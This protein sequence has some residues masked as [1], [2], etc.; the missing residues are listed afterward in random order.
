MA[1]CGLTEHSGPVAADHTWIACASAATVQLP[2]VSL[3]YMPQ[4]VM[5][6]FQST[7]GGA[8]SGGATYFPSRNRLESSRGG[9]LPSLRPVAKLLDYQGWRYPVDGLLSG[10]PRDGPV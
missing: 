9:R 3:W 4:S 5:P 7:S 8:G 6:L 1:I 10:W 2:S